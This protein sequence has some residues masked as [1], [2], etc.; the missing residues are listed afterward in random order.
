MD[1]RRQALN[2]I[3]SQTAALRDRETRLA[4]AEERARELAAARTTIE[5]SRSWR[6]TAPVRRLS[7]LLHR[8]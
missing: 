2:E 5:G 4:A 3:E 7:A 6:V 8:L 1:L